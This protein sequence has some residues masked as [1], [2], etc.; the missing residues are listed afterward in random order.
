MDEPLPD[1]DNNCL[2]DPKIKTQA[3]RELS[4]RLADL[5]KAIE[6]ATGALAQLGAAPRNEKPR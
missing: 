6:E 4:K 1:N 3:L 2:L 5:H